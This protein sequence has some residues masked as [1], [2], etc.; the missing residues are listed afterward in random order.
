[1]NEEKINYLY[2]RTLY[3]LKFRPRSEKEISDYLKK[4][5]K[6]KNL[7]DIDFQKVIAT[8]KEQGLIDDK[9]FIDW[10]L[11][12]RL[13]GKP[14]SQWLLKKE[15]LRFGVDENLIDECL[16][17]LK[18]NEK[19]LIEKII[20]THPRIFANLSNE[21]NKLRAIRFLQRRGFSYEAI[22]K[23]V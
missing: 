4:I 16:S 3:F 14:K 1:M 22:K 6:K 12:S 11:Q 21:K 18:I 9:N 23:F 5:I 20:Q 7:S 8:L 17:K 10:F 2:Q 15:L 19:E 13:S